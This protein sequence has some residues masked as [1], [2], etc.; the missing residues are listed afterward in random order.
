MQELYVHFIITIFICSLSRRVATCI[1]PLTLTYL[2]ASQI[3]FSTNTTL[4]T[5]RFAFTCT[6]QIFQKIWRSLTNKVNGW[7]SVLIF[8]TKI[9]RRIFQVVALCL[10][11]S[12]CKSEGKLWEHVERM[13]LHMVVTLPSLHPSALQSI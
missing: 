11:S 3:L 1:S 7:Q 4:R 13:K 5:R 9:L 12:R 6:Q 10:T 8:P 2:S